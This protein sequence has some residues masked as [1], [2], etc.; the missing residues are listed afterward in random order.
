[1]K[2]TS[3]T[4]PPA[5]L[6]PLHGEAE[7]QLARAA[8]DETAPASSADL[9]HELRV[10]Q[11]ELEMQNEALRQTQI[12]LEESR[13]RYLNLYEFASVGYITLS[14]TGLITEINLTGA[15]ML[16]VERKKL[17]N[18]RPA[19]FVTAT[20][21]ERCN[22]HLLSAFRHEGRSD[23]AIAIDAY[24]GCKRELHLDCL[25]V[26][27]G[28]GKPT[29]KLTL[30]DITERRFAERK[31]DRERIRFDEAMQSKNIELETAKETAERA[32]LAKSALLS[33]VSHE[34]RS[35]L[36][37]VIGF[38][39]LLE[40]AKTPPSALQKESIDQILKAG[41][42][43]LGLINEILDL[44]KIESGKVAV[45]HEAISLSEVLADCQALIGPHASQHAID[46]RFPGPEHSFQVH[47]DRTAIKQIMLNLLSNA[48]KYNRQDGS[49]TVECEMR[50]EDRLR[51]SVTDTGIGLSARQLAQLFQPFNRLG[52][53]L[54]REEGTGI[55]L[56]ISKQLVELMN[57]VIGA[58][59]SP[60]SGSVFWFDL[61]ASIPCSPAL[62]AAEEA[63]TGGADRLTAEDFPRPFTLLY[64]EDHPADLILVEKLVER[65]RDV[66]F[67]SAGDA[68]LGIQLTLSDKPDLI[69]MDIRLP[70]IS[71]M[72]A[73]KILRANPASARIPIVAIS[74]NAMPHDIRKALQAGFFHYLTKPF[75]VGEFMDMLDAAIKL[76]SAKPAQKGAARSY[77]GPAF[78]GAPL[79]S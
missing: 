46:V 51:V 79:R 62:H 17:L 28:N 21:R 20:D 41:W 54:G 61:P 14:Q 45:S 26:N 78:S 31:A 50:A 27:D 53:E 59:S 3:S 33:T 12:A 47:G 18:R 34:L 29:L 69:L 16:G 49:V 72:D 48:I 19:A 70:G 42:Y 6:T 77:A 67:L 10:H 15:T 2:W 74:A 56:V 71:G 44:A 11:I 76:A 38:A 4:A 1:M 8:P 73:L 40:S 36:N 7:A 43:L 75:E 30:T 68:D 23:F 60:G 57:G 65:R 25:P 66:Q 13:D 39:Q 52:Q 22:R 9:L 63:E 35:P 64:I 5:A 37:A 24:G 58:E 32:N 55:G